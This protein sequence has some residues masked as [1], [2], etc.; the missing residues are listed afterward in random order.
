MAYAEALEAA[1]IASKAYS[2]ALRA[3][4]ALEIGDAQFLEAKA[5]Y[6]QSEI[7]FDAAHAQ[8]D[9]T[10]IP[11][12]LGW[13]KEDFAVDDEERALRITDQS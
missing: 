2:E 13:S 1:R 12:K 11:S 5:V 6:L 3:Y 4:R 10:R 9:R 8:E 7:A